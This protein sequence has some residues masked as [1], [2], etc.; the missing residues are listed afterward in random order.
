MWLVEEFFLF[1]QLFSIIICIIIIIN[2]IFSL[3]LWHFLC[4]V[5]GIFFIL[6]TLFNNITYYNNNKSYIFFGTVTFFVVGW[7]I[8]YLF[9]QLFSIMIYIIILINHI[10]CYKLWHFFYG[11]LNEFSI[12]IS[13][14]NNNNM[15]YNINK[16]YIFWS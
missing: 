3:K 10:H 6:T 14:L 8:F 4:L 1:W 7:R 11:W 5:V 2:H 15:H 12:L 9:W 13:T 16:S